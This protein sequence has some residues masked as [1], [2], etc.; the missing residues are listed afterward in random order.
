VQVLGFS[1]GVVGGKVVLTGNYDESLIQ[2][3]PLVADVVH[4]PQK[5]RKPKKKLVRRMVPDDSQRLRHAFQIAFLL[6]NVWIGAQF[7]FWVR[8][9]EMVNPVSFSRPA[10]VD[11]W[12]PIS[13]LMN[14][15][16]WIATGNIPSVHPA[17][18]FLL[19]AFL[20]MA[21]LLRKAF[22]SWLCPVGTIS[23]SLWR[24]GRKLFRRNFAMPRWLD[25]PLRGLKYLLLGFFVAAVDMMPAASIR[26]FMHTPFGIVADVK[27]LN[28]FRFISQTG[29]IV[30]GVLVVGS[31]LLKNFWCR[32][33]CP[34]GA[35]LG[36]VSLF[37]P[38]GIR[39][40]EERC[41]DC[42]KCA[43]ACPSALPV[44]RLPAVHSAEC[45]GCMECIAVCPAEGA[46]VMSIARMPGV[47]RASRRLPAWAV[48]AGIAAIFL[49]I[50]GYAKLSGHWQT[51]LPKAVYQQL[52]PRANEATHPMP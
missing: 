8:G 1:V 14:L 47:K 43:K 25:V 7:Y 2:I 46:L 16:V 33:L 5:V 21:F 29:L 50:V 18:M 30:I 9:Y 40:N 12:L 15:K 19:V 52:V 13:G 23:E 26:E 3:S 39:R 36:L 17:A 27:M 6:L 48:A 20:A 11:G 44:D 22:C 34:Y 28:F 42:A 31:L 24:L 41:I 32:Y 38:V 37:S 51:N 45:T 10:G 35:L 4:P 49:G